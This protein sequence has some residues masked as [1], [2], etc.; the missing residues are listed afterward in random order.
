VAVAILRWARHFCWI[1]MWRQDFCDLAQPPA[2]E[3]LLATKAA[4]AK[5][6]DRLPVIS[7]HIVHGP[8]HSIRLSGSRDVRC[9]SAG[10]AEK[11]NAQPV[12]P[13]NLLVTNA[14][15]SGRRGAGR[16]S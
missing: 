10:A 9:P 7:S 13:P 5:R 2:H 15:W 1:Q 3:T 12:L 8:C 6:H 16:G 4:F 11:T 14:A